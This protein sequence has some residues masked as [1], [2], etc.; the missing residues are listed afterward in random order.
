[1][2]LAATQPALAWPGCRWS[3][4]SGL[5]RHHYTKRCAVQQPFPSRS[6]LLESKIMQ[7]LSLLTAPFRD[8]VRFVV[9]ADKRHPPR[10][11]VGVVLPGGLFSVY[12]DC[13]TEEAAKR[14]AYCMNVQ[15]EK[16][17]DHVIS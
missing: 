7:Q 12:L 11:L 10:H 4:S 16:D 6:D 14:A 3:D 5:E 8:P 15:Y 2:A 1:M 17:H 13:L 9:R